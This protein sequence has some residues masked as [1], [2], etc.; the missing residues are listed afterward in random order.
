MLISAV[1]DMELW[2]NRRNTRPYSLTASVLYW[3]VNVVLSYNQDHVFTHWNFHE[4]S[5][6]WGRAYSN[7]SKAPQPVHPYSAT[8][9][10]CRFLFGVCSHWG[11]TG[12]VKAISCL[13]QLNQ[14]PLFWAVVYLCV[15]RHWRR[16]GNVVY[17]EL[18][19]ATW[20][21]GSLLLHR[22]GL[23]WQWWLPRACQ[24]HCGGP[25]LVTAGQLFYKLRPLSTSSQVKAWIYQRTGYNERA[26]PCFQFFPVAT[27]DM[28]LNIPL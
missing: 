1:T 27:W 18:W 28:Q 2:S 20:G 14:D 17:R 25:M 8:S 26:Q 7:V 5:Q 13:C 15:P 6:P 16:P 4:R 3:P 21:F 22:F 11:D 10:T 23:D 24:V 19:F 9:Q 12:L